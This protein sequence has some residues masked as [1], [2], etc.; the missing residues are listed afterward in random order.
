[1]K[2]AAADIERAI[3][4]TVEDHD[5]STAEEVAILMDY[6]ARVTAPLASTEREDR[7]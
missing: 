3:E 2:R 6:L 4:R 7:T 5:L 1:M